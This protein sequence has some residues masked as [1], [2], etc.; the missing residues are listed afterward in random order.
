MKRVALCAMVAACGGSSPPPAGSRIAPAIGAVLEAAD[1]LRAPWRCAAADGPALADETLKIGDH[2]WKLAARTVRMDDAAT[3]TI[4][5]IADAAGAAPPTLVALGALRARFATADLVIA[6][7]G[8]GATQAELEATLGAL[9]DHAAWPVIALPGDLEPAAAQAAAIAALRARG[10]IVID[11][12]LARR[13]E[14]PGATIAT[15]PGAGAASRLVAGSEGCGYSPADVAAAFDDLTAR[16]GL[17]ILASAEAPRIAVHGEPAGELALSTGATRQPEMARAPEE[18]QAR[19]AQ[20]DIALHGPTSEAASA[21]RAGGRDSLAVPLTPGSSDA[22]TRLPGTSRG[23][24]AGLLTITGTAWR[25][26][27]ITDAAR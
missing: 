17:R 4:G 23:S 10:Q 11:G 3:V 6:L 21:G 19:R 26:T 27:P 22:T 14:L 18:P 5:V 9:A 15:I 20:I 8:M 25:W 12:R 2:T 24:S 16:P 1:G 13:I 7:G